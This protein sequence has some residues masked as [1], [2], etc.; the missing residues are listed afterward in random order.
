MDKRITTSRRGKRVPDRLWV[1]VVACFSI[2]AATVIYFAFRSK[3][4]D[5]EVNVEKPKVKVATVKPHVAEPKAGKDEAST[6]ETPKMSSEP[7]PEEVAPVQVEKSP[8]EGEVPGEPPRRAGA[9]VLDKDGNDVF[10]P[11]PELKTRTDK[12]L[13]SVLRRPFGAGKVNLNIYKLDEDF[14]KS[15]EA[16]VEILETDTEEEKAIKME[17]EGY[18]QELAK[19]VEAG[20]S[21]VELLDDIRNEAN[22]AAAE[23]AEARRKLYELIKNGEFDAAEIYLTAINKRFAEEGVLQLHIP[24]KLIKKAVAEHGEEYFKR[25]QKLEEAERRL[26]KTDDAQ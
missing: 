20:E 19:R 3:T 6:A 26:G 17:I 13:F 25:E 12:F 7:P 1:A 16:P 10:K 24:E 8:E 18:K 15:L 9:R 14:K 4:P 21:I 22:L 5:G 2:A 23:H 11:R